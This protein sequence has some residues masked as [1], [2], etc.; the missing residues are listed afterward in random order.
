MAASWRSSAILVGMS[1]HRISPST[2]NVI[3]RL[4]FRLSIRV[5]ES[6]PCAVAKSLPL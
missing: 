1:S 6:Y 4:S 5:S 2:G 3:R